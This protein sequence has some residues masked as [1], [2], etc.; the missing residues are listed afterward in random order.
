MYIHVHVCY[1]TVYTCTCTYMYVTYCTCTVYLHKRNNSHSLIIVLVNL[2]AST[3][4]YVFLFQCG[5]SKNIPPGTVVDTV[6]THP[7]EF[8][9]FLCSHAG[10][11]VIKLSH[12]PPQ[13][14]TFTLK[15]NNKKLF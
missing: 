9:F 1:L 4:H 2:Q 10:I 13:Y 12:P 11:Q 6:I 8:D 14:F 3:S 7:R 5:R 15:F